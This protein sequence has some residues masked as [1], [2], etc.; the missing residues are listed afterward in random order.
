[1]N[2][3]LKMYRAL[4][5]PLYYQLVKTWIPL[6]QLQDQEWGESVDAGVGADVGVDVDEGESHSVGKVM[7][8]QVV[9]S[10]LEIV[11]S[12]CLTGALDTQ[13]LKDKTTSKIC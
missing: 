5:L 9:P 7:P 8:C 3:F 12:D 1:M 2:M 10:Q 11:E 4:S 13:D 6:Y